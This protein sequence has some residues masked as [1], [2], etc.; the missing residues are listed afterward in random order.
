MTVSDLQVRRNAI[1]SP[2]RPGMECVVKH[3][4]VLACSDACSTPFATS[5]RC[6]KGADVSHCACVSYIHN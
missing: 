1:L 4:A 3:I 6:G 2:R 5:P